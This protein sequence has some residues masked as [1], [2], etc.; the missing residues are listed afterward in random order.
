MVPRVS[1]SPQVGWPAFGNPRAS[2]NQRSYSPSCVLYLRLGLLSAEQV[3]AEALQ[4]II[5]GLNANLDRG[6]RLVFVK[7]LEQKYCYCSTMRSTT[8]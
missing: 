2:R 7:I 5:N 3:V 1:P 4:K 6:G 8:E